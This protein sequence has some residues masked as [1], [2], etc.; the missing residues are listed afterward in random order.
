ME[1][2]IF[3]RIIKGEIPCHKIY[4]DE[5][6]FAFLDIHPS[7]PGHVLVVSKTQ[8]EFIW[9]LKDDDYTA[10]MNAVK[11]VGTHMREVFSQKQ[12]GVIVAGI[13]VPHVHVHLI[14]FTTEAELKAP[15]DMSSEPDHAALARMAE[16]LRLS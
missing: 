14:P 2:S 6:T 12:I 9:D 13:G 4:E 8:T 5:A 15:Q 3:T 10:L 16:K 11:T 1:D 7:Q